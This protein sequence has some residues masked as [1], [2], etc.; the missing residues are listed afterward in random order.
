M[1]AKF[2]RCA[3]KLHLLQV[4]W[5]PAAHL[6]CYFAPLLLCMALGLRCKPGRKTLLPI[7]LS[8][9]DCDLQLLFQFI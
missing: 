5:P 1:L 4:D 8:W 2:A 9:L 3:N 6:L 7:S